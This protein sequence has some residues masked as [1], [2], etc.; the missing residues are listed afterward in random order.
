MSDRT[1][2]YKSSPSTLDHTS[3]HCNQ[4]EFEHVCEDIKLSFPR[5]ALT[6]VHHTSSKDQAPTQY[7]QSVQNWIL[8]RALEHG[9]ND[10]DCLEAIDKAFSG[11]QERAR[12]YVENSSR[13]AG[14]F[15]QTILAERGNFYQNWFK[16]DAT[17]ET[18]LL[19]QNGL[20][21]VDSLANQL[22]KRL[23]DSVELPER[24]DFHQLTQNAMKEMINE[25]K[26]PQE[27][28]SPKDDLRYLLANMTLPEAI[29]FNKTRQA[30]GRA[31][32]P[33]RTTALHE[34]ADEMERSI[35]TKIT[36]DLNDLVK[37]AV[38]SDNFKQTVEDHSSLETAR[39]ALKDQVENTLKDSFGPDWQDVQDI[40]D[41]MDR[42]LAIALHGDS[43]YVK[44][45]RKLE[46]FERKVKA[47]MEDHRPTG[48]AQHAS[49]MITANQDG[50]PNPPLGLLK[51]LE[52]IS[53]ISTFHE[54][55]KHR[56][57]QEIRK[58]AGERLTAQYRQEIAHMVLEQW[59]NAQSKPNESD[60]LT[61]I[62]GDKRDWTDE[63]G[64]VHPINMAADLQKYQNESRRNNAQYGAARTEYEHLVRDVAEEFRKGTYAQIDA[65][66]EK[67]PNGFR[68]PDRIPELLEAY[69][70]LN[71][72][73]AEDHIA[74]RPEIADAKE[75]IS[76]I[77]QRAKLLR[78]KYEKTGYPSMTDRQTNSQIMDAHRNWTAESPGHEGTGP[79]HN[80]I[81]KAI[82]AEGT[83]YLIAQSADGDTDSKARLE[84]I[85]LA[86]QASGELAANNHMIKPDG[87][88]ASP[89]VEALL[90]HYEAGHH[91]P[92]DA[93]DP[94]LWETWGKERTKRAKATEAAYWGY[95]F[96]EKDRDHRETW[97]KNPR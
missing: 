73:N 76:E 51:E 38:N 89:A 2:G 37:T 92:Q 65:L 55:M 47:E 56:E 14:E 44:D 30:E 34:A 1:T 67:F 27:V 96:Q 43:S 8:E 91:N 60:P 3:D 82:R 39:Q 33:E 68:N 13:Y 85:A 10:D 78:D 63:Q 21:K 32:S 16:I 79:L 11:I 94:Q 80:L 40:Q 36:N 18:V 17:E 88:D 26:N 86:L 72:Q 52:R 93:S 7:T 41:L 62:W 6:D 84:Y 45:L 53:H 29:R 22:A 66:G 64:L 69:R 42:A 97:S 46:S 95:H 4:E 49:N 35:H 70:H 20:Q 48:T 5:N 71:S 74:N 83:G 77:I 15:A 23:G 75:R 90:S 19:T 50:Q 9:L 59:P 58:L 61:A 87:S 54:R 57:A 28:F 31:W 25:E 12:A 81:A 24:E